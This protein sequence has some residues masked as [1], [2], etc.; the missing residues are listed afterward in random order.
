MLFFVYFWLVI[1]SIFQEAL[2][3]LDPIYKDIMAESTEK[4][5]FQLSGAR[6]M[7]NEDRARELLSHVNIDNNLACTTIKLSNKSFSPEAAAV[8]V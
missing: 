4:C 8:I 1:I 3:T 2:A 6:E 7:V 5:V